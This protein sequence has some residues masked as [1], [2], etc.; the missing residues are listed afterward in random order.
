MYA[1]TVSDVHILPCTYIFDASHQDSLGKVALAAARSGNATEVVAHGDCIRGASYRTDDPFYKV[2]EA[3]NDLC[4]L[5]FATELMLHFMAEGF[6]Y[7][8]K[9]TNVFDALIVV[10]TLINNIVPLPGISAVRLFRLANLINKSARF[11]SLKLIVGSIVSSFGPLTSAVSLLSLFLFI[12]AVGGLQL[13][14]SSLPGH[15][16]LNFRDFPSALLTVFVMFTG[17]WS[18]V[19]YK[20]ASVEGHWSM[21]FF[22]LFVIYGLLSLSMLILAGI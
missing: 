18:P 5:L 8:E 4:S 21:L 12:F 22:F 15:D 10:L 14:G 11:K 3:I 17:D 20:I 9:L 6:R 2:F 16:R 13:F 1:I 7:Y 19:M